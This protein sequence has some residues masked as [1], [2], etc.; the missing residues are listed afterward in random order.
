MSSGNNTDKAVVGREGDT[1]TMMPLSYASKSHDDIEDNAKEVI[2]ATGNPWDQVQRGQ[3]NVDV[4]ATAL[5]TSTRA[6][7]ACAAADSTILGD[8]VKDSHDDRYLSSS[9]CSPSSPFEGEPPNTLRKARPAWAPWR[10]CQFCV[11]TQLFWTIWR[12]TFFTLLVLLRSGL[13]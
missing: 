7:N 8:V 12:S 6:E 9:A 3:K 10:A 11:T 2:V 13:A 5:A 4:S 1:M